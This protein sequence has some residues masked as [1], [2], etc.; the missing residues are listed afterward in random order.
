MQRGARVT[1]LRFYYCI[2]VLIL[3]HIC[4]LILLYKCVRRCLLRLGKT[5]KRQK[6][7]PRGVYS[8]TALVSALF[9]ILEKKK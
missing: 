3:L 5:I 4:V 8:T 9:L 1:R 6:A 2:C 7:H